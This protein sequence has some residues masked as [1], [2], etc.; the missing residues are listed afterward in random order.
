MKVTWETCRAER[1]STGVP[2]KRPF[3]TKHMKMLPYRITKG[4][5]LAGAG[6]DLSIEGG[7]EYLREFE[8]E[9]PSRP[10]YDF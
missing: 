2:P 9:T 8:A 5:W 3:C 7:I 10:A 6:R 4:L 1:C